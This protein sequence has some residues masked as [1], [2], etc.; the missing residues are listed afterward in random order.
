MN[1]GKYVFAQL[2]GFYSRRTF[3]RIHPLP[4]GLR[5][6]W[7][8]FSCQ[9]GDHWGTG[10]LQDDKGVIAIFLTFVQPKYFCNEKN[11]Y[12]FVGPGVDGIYPGMWPKE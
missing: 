6:G 1:Q 9:G 5:R 12:R 7:R 11:V 10:S 4:P 2:A 3:E 8:F